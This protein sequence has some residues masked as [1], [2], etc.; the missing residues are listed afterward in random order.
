[1]TQDSEG[2]FLKKTPTNQKTQQT[3]KSQQ[4]KKSKPNHQPQNL[5]LPI[6]NKA[7]KKSLIYLW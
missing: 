5:I 7:N 4:N 1:M 6:K 3:H 2:F